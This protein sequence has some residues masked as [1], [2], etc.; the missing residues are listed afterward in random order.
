MQTISYTSA[1]Q[2][3]AETMDVVIDSHEPVI[4]TRQKAG[5]VVMMSL[6]FYNSMQETA[7]L[8]GHPANAKRLHNAILQ[9][10][11]GEVVLLEDVFNECMHPT[12][13]QRC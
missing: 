2:R 12:D 9:A 1:R 4:I 10:D 7:Y 6:E 8:L 11:G 3:L 5:E 13:K